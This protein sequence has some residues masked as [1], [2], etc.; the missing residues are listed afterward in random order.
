MNSEL[1]TTW[2][3]HDNS[4]Q[5]IL[6]LAK[7][8]L[9]IFDEDL[10]RLNLERAE[11]AEI[12]RRFLAADERSSLRIVVKNADPFQRSCPRLMKLLT[13]YPHKMAVVE[14]P[15]QLASLNDALF[16]VDDRHALVRFHK[17]NVRS[18]MIVDNPGDCLPYVHRFEEIVKEGGTPICA[19][20]LG[21]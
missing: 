12:L 5:K 11:N 9:S 7:Q 21:L 18:R 10:S 6:A 16:I 14:C 17:D 8:R 3:E 1:I 20:T 4:L 15:L 2:S 19:T 13:L